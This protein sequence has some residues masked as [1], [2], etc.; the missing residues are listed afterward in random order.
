MKEDE[1]IIQRAYMHDPWVR[2]TV[3]ELTMGVG[4]KLEGGGQKGK[5][6]E[7][8]NSINNK[9]VFFFKRKILY[10]PVK[11]NTMVIKRNDFM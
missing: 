8:C 3:W 9:K 2:I 5:N 10:L 11:G 6:L 4:Y 1:G 7:H